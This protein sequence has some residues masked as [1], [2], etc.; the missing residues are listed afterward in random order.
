MSK[1]KIQYLPTAQIAELPRNNYRNEE[2]FIE[3]EL[4]ELG[5]RIKEDGQLSPIGV[6][7]FPD[8]SKML[9]Y[10]ERRLRACI[11]AGVENIQ[12]CEFTVNDMADF[13]RKQ[14][15]ENLDRANTDAVSDGFLFKEMNSK[16]VPLVE[17]ARN[18]QFP[19]NIKTREAQ[20]EFIKGR[21]ALANCHP[22]VHKAY[23]AGLLKE[24]TSGENQALLFVT[25]PHDIQEKVADYLLSNGKAQTNDN[26]NRLFSQFSFSFPCAN[27]PFPQNWFT[28]DVCAILDEE[29]VCIDENWFRAKLEEYHNQ[30]IQIAKR[31]AESTVSGKVYALKSTRR[32]SIHDEK[33]ENPLHI[34][35]Y[36]ESTKGKSTHTKVGLISSRRVDSD[37]CRIIYFC[38][39]DSKCPVHFQSEEKAR[40]EARKERAKTANSQESIRLYAKKAVEVLGSKKWNELPDF[41]Y[42]AAELTR[43]F[44]VQCSS[45]VKKRVAALVGTTADLI[46]FNSKGWKSKFDAFAESEKLSAE[47]A[48]AKIITFASWWKCCDF[49]IHHKTEFDKLGLNFDE[50]EK[51]A[52]N[53]IKI[54]EDKK[55]SERVRKE[56]H[57]ATM[58]AT[59]EA[60]KAKNVDFTDEMSVL[61]HITDDATMKKLCRDMGINT[62]GL[63]DPG[64][65][66]TLAKTVS[67]KYNELCQLGIITDQRIEATK[68]LEDEE[69]EEDDVENNDDNNNG[70]DLPFEEDDDDDYDDEYDENEQE[71]EEEADIY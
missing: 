24:F 67:I 23:R 40:E 30:Q 38:D 31:M 21:I 44:V 10:G 32:Q 25:F 60:A 28:P 37:W 13:K 6:A 36:V 9:C 26:I 53:N 45:E 63:T 50:I 1:N 70:N 8:K 58:I 27:A 71:Y 42:P 46:N 54:R 61:A 20:V 39:L 22:S 4:L 16:G 69:E 48:S 14:A 11:L 65:R 62:K 12:V 55:E 35:G 68:W 59:I 19:K 15:T 64:D 33:D 49:A 56:A 5:E 41:E 43:L 7:I 3:S 17:I 47:K 66:L 52:Q 29:S 51:V 34:Y 57:Q 2:E 18:I